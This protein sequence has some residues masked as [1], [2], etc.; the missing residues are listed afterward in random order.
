MKAIVLL[1]GGLDSAVAGSWAK[2][3]FKEDCVALC[4]DYGQRHKKEIECSRKLA[5]HYGW[6]WRMLTIEI[7]AQ[8]ALLDPA[9]DLNQK[10]KGLPATFVPGRNLIFLSYA[11]SLAYHFDA[12]RIVGGWNDVDYSGYPDCRPQFL[13][14]AGIVLNLALGFVGK[15]DVTGP[16]LGLSKKEIVLKGKELRTPFH[17]TWSC[18]FGGETPCGECD[19]CR[20]RKKGFEEAGVKDPLER[21]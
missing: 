13:S 7:P 15:I 11:A 3:R 4:F 10:V 18:Y 2:M 12:E 21:R 19:S 17:L 16:L 1:S 20:F 14:M 9:K 5:D 6:S 8:S